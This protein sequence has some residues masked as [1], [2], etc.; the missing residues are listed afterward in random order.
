MSKIETRGASLNRARDGS[1]AREVIYGKGLGPT[2]RESGKQLWSY[3]RIK[4]SC[5]FGIL[6]KVKVHQSVSVDLLFAI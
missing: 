3:V 1:N 4:R 2:A 6:P 5:D